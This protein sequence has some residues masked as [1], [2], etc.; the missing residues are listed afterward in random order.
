VPLK[1]SAVVIG[2][3]GGVGSGVVAEL[4]AAGYPVIAVG[5]DGTKLQA[6]AQRVGDASRLTLLPG[7]VATDAEASA[8]AQALRNLRVRLSATIVAVNGRLRSASVLNGHGDLV[9]QSLGENFIPHLHAA[10]HLV[11]LMA[12]IGRE[13]L[14][15]M[16]GGASAER[17]WAGYGHVSIASAALRMLA[18]VV[19]G[20]AK[21]LPVRVQELLLWGVVRTHE[22]QTIACPEWLVAGDVGRQ[23]VRMITDSDGVLPVVHMRARG[24]GCVAEHKN[25]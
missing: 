18:G 3:S 9:A 11:P 8:L 1:A 20:E 21:N 13:G 7:S 17:V 16:L 24:G 23:V 10:R 6:L 19:H 5:R 4:L 25:T 12:D 2:G 14:Y 15:L 22:N